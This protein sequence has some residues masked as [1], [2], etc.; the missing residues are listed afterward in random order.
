MMRAIS[1]RKK[2]IIWRLILIS[3]RT[4]FEIID[5][6]FR[7]NVIFSETFKIRKA[8]ARVFLLAFF[9]HTIFL[10]NSMFKK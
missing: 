4:F 1:L 10:K 5:I 9:K 2:T 7:K 8:T 3:C 6:S